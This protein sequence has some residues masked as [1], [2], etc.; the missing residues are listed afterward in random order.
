MRLLKIVTVVVLV[1]VAGVFA[2]AAT[3][4]DTFRVQRTTT[5]NAPPASIVKF[6]E[7]FRAWP[8]WSPYEKLDPAMKKTLTG[9]SS[10]KGAVYEWEGN[11]QAGK[12][13]ME[14]LDSSPSRVRIQL[15]FEKPFTSH[16]MAEFRLVPHGSSTS[17]T[18]AMEG[19]NLFIGKVM[20]VFIDVDTMVGGD[21]ESG[22]AA[23]KSLAEK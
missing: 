22:L 15:D 9:A 1:L 23:L 14:I 19:P 13:R 16:N 20:S 3:K 10:G 5:I 21:F 6:V 17:V 2:Y 8:A 7:D 12:G 18:W 4:P 11:S